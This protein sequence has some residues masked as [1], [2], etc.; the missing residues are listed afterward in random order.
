[1]T[2][3][4]RDCTTSTALCMEFYFLF[5]I[6]LF[7]RRSMCTMSHPHFFSLSFLN[8]LV[9]LLSYPL[10]GYHLVVY[11]GVD[12]RCPFFVFS[13]GFIMSVLS[14]PLRHGF[15]FLLTREGKTK[16]SCTSHI[17]VICLCSLPLIV[18]NKTLLL[19]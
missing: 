19:V 18:S 6:F 13:I 12:Y 14:F 8:Q 5:K 2:V 10:L 3:D 9:S 17:I 7:F 16:K 4:R 11:Y 1:M 15:Q